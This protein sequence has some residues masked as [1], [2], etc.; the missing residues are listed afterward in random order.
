MLRLVLASNIVTISH[1]KK[2]EMT[3]YYIDQIMNSP[4]GSFI[5][6]PLLR[7]DHV[8]LRVSNLKKSVDF[9]QSI[10]GF[11]VLEKKHDGNNPSFPCR[12]R[13]LTFNVLTCLN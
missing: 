2:A 11:K 12:W 7:I 9:Y 8:H 4:N 3:E 6:S 13:G 5:A 10:L 1:S